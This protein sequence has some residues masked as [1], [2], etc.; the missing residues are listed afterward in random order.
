MNQQTCLCKWKHHLL[1]STTSSSIGAPRGSQFMKVF[2]CIIGNKLNSWQT[3]RDKKYQI[4]HNMV[5][6]ELK[7]K[8]KIVHSYGS[9]KPYT[10]YYCHILI[11]IFSILMTTLKSRIHKCINTHSFNFN[12]RTQKQ[13]WQLWTC[14]L[15]TWRE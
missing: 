10:V 7:T 6:T 13:D 14:S 15:W 3:Q 9:R 8:Q 2:T 1:L 11:Y 4:N 12:D 5:N